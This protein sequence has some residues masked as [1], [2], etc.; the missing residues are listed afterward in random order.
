MEYSY[1]LVTSELCLLSFVCKK[2]ILVL[3]GLSSSK[4]IF[5]IESSTIDHSWGSSFGLRLELQA[6]EESRQQ[7]LENTTG[8]VVKLLLS[9]K[10]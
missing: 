2:I 9:G 7:Q 1:L 8:E 4:K 5:L 6:V 3:D 10:F